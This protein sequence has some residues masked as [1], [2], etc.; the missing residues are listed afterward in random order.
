M[1]ANN[2]TQTW[3]LWLMAIIFVAGIIFLPTTASMSN[4][5]SVTVMTINRYCSCVVLLMIDGAKIDNDS[6]WTTAS[7]D[8]LLVYLKVKK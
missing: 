5:E 6:S 1:S 2:N 3:K 8:T 7:G 4:D